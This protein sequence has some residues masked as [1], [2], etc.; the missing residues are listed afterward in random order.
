MNL[1]LVMVKNIMQ[2]LADNFKYVVPLIFLNQLHRLAFAGY[3][4]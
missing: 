3:R 4:L 1:H 2:I